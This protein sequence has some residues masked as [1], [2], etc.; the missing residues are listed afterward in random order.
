MFRGVIRW[1]REKGHNPGQYQ[2]NSGKK[3]KSIFRKSSE[4]RTSITRKHR[5]RDGQA[6]LPDRCWKESSM[7]CEPGVSGKLLRENMGVAAV[8]TGIFK[9][10]RQRV[11]LKTYGYW[12]WRNMTN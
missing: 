8:F 5:D 11:S 2:T 10:G 3:S 6:C 1:K 9:N 12:A 4:I 7:F